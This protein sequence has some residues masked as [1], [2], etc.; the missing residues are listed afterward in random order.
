MQSEV[1]IM[2]ILAQQLIATTVF[3]FGVVAAVLI[4]DGTARLVV[5]ILGG[6]AVGV[7]VWIIPSLRDGSSSYSTRE[8]DDASE[9]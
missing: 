2:R 3:V 9:E 5:C 7:L 1:A 6:S 8:G 4:E